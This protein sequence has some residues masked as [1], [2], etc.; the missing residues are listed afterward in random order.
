MRLIKPL[1]LTLVCNFPA[2]TSH[3][4]DSDNQICAS[5]TQTQKDQTLKLPYQVSEFWYNTQVYVD[6]DEKILYHVEKHTVLKESEFEANFAK[7]FK[8]KWSASPMCNNLVIKDDF[9][10]QFSFTLQDLEGPYLT[11]AT[12][13]YQTC[14]E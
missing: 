7:K 5:L 8:N 3:A 6:C 10:W 4:S 14:N 12:A 13:D 11:S 1:M 2:S 9:G